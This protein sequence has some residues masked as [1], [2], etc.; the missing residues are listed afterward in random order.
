[1]VG[2]TFSVPKASSVVRHWDSELAPF[3]GPELLAGPARP[4]NKIN[5]LAEKEKFEYWN[6]SH[7][8]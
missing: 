6:E 8:R 5:K 1:M 2:I 4:L 7:A 3:G